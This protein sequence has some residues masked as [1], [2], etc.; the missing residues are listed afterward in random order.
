MPIFQDRFCFQ[1]AVSYEKR[2]VLDC[3][4]LLCEMHSFGQ[5]SSITIPMNISPQ[6]ME[7]I[8][9]FKCSRERILIV[10]IL[11]RKIAVAEVTEKPETNLL[12]FAV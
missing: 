11:W 1:N 7:T 9:R 3:E 12:E 4:G 6:W 10:M 8:P 5:A 2:Y